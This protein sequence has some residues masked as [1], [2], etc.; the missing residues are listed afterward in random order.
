MVYAAATEPPAKSACVKHAETEKDYGDS[1]STVGA[2][3]RGKMLHN[4]RWSSTSDSN[5][6]GSHQTREGGFICPKDDAKW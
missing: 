6:N 2:Q 3:P 5:G 1:N 4:S